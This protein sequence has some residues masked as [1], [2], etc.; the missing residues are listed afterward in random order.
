MGWRRWAGGVLGICLVANSVWSQGAATAPDRFT[1]KPRVVILSD[2]GNEPDDQMSFVRLLLYSNE[3]DLEAMVAAT[4]TWQKTVTHPETMHRLIDAYGEVRSNLLLH[5]QGW[6]TAEQLQERVY[7][8]QPQYGMAATGAGKASAGAAALAAAI[9][10]DDPRPLWIC[11]WGGANTLAQALMDIRARHSAEEAQK[12]VERLRVYSISDQDDA[13]P[14]IRREFPS[15][16]YI[17][18]PSMPSGQQYYYAT[19][20]GISGDAYYRNGAGADPSLVTNEWLDQNIRS[21]GPLGK[22]YPKFMFIMEGD[23]PSFLGLIDNGL[24]AYRR[25]DWGG[26]GGRYVYMQPYGETHAIW[27][28]GGDL[29]TRATSQDAVKGIDGREYVSDQATIWRWRRAYQ[30]DFAAR[31]DWT[32]HD[33]AHAN[34]SPQVVVNGVAGT[35]PAEMDVAVG[36]T[37]T[38][39]ATGSKDPDGQTLSYRWWVY[40][41]AGLTGTHASEVAIDKAGAQVATVTVKGLCAPVWLPNLMP[42]RTDGVVHIIL[43]VT[44]TGTPQL[45]SYRRVILHVHAVASQAARPQE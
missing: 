22:D 12:L 3:F 28:Q 9:E 40:P 17:V 25:P 5:A 34:H 35:A 16:L 30:N 42:C 2:I 41:E 6:P 15:L 43:E 10:R 29:F 27:T 24:N 20:T 7:S 33:F 21:K 26:W 19:W 11:I 31:M 37:V 45:T 38:L 4:S 8:G 14:W 44:D 39:D 36:Q 1:G 32:I 18:M 13:G 23:T